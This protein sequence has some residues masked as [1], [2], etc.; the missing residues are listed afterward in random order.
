MVKILFEQILVTK[1]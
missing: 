1:G